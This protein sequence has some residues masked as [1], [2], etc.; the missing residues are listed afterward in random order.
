VELNLEPSS[1]D[2][3]FAERHY[4]PASEVVPKW[5]ERMLG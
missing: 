4:G 2:F 3:M 1:G 5:V